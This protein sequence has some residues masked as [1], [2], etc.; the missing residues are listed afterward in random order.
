MRKFLLLLF[1]LVLASIDIFAQRYNVY[2]KYND[3]T[4][5]RD[6]SVYAFNSKR[7]AEEAC[8]NYATLYYVD[9]E[10]VKPIGSSTTNA[11]GYCMLEADRRAWIVVDEYLGLK[12][13]AVIE[14]AK[15]LDESGDVRITL[16][17]TKGGK[18][19]E[20]WKV[21]DETDL[22]QLEKSQMQKP[23]PPAPPIPESYGRM[24]LIGGDFTIDGD[25]ARN[26]A[27][28]VAFPRVVFPDLDSVLYLKPVVV[29]GKSYAQSMERRMGFDLENDK[30]EHYHLDKSFFM[31]SHADDYFNYIQYVFVD[32]GIRYFSDAQVWYEDYNGIY[33]RYVQKLQDGKEAKTMRFLDW[34]AAKRSI[35][36][37]A[38]QYAKEG[39]IVKANDSQEFHLEFEVGKETLNLNDSA[40]VSERNELLRMFNGYL[41]NR[42]TE[43]L[44]VTVKGYSSP[45]GLYARNSVLS[46]GRTNTIA[47]LLKREFPRISGDIKAEYDENN[48]VVPWD[49]I[50]SI[51]AKSTD[52]AVLRYVA[53]VRDVVSKKSGFDAQQAEL[54]KDKGLWEYV[55]D[56][57]L[58]SV[59]RV[60]VDVELQVSKVLTLEEIVERYHEKTLFQPD[61]KV[62]DYQYY[63]LMRWLAANEKWDELYTISKMAYEDRSMI[64]TDRPKYILYGNTASKKAQ[65]NKDTVDFYMQSKPG[66]AYLQI[67]TTDETSGFSDKSE[68]GVK[69]EYR[70]NGR[71]INSKSVHKP[72]VYDFEIYINGVV[73]RYRQKVELSA[74][75]PL[76][77]VLEIKNEA[78]DYPYPLAAYYYA[79]CMLQRGEVNTRILSQFLDD[80]PVNRKLNK[81]IQFNDKAII[82]TQVLMYCQDDDFENANRLIVTYGLSAEDPDLKSL[83][84]FVR[85]LAGEYGHPEIQEFIMS[86]SPLNEAVILAALQRWQDALTKLKTLPQDDA[87]IQYLTA[88]CRYKSQPNSLIQLDAS[89]YNSAFI[90]TIGAPMIE[91]F[92]LDKENVKYIENDGYFNDA[93]RLLVLY[94]WKRMSDGLSIDEISAEYDA[95]VDKYQAN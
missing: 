85:C 28:F 43:I 17:R 62:L 44:N 66:Y 57:V 59:R 49:T 92:K 94:F 20:E 25:L 39:K 69:I 64:Q 19:K 15:C 80:G 37:D 68:N 50:A 63:E 36:I 76:L 40:T 56:S 65:I 67:E 30:L 46:R 5:A 4:V 42:E 52:P 29:D 82:A 10:S 75:E 3:G 91:A 7:L 81:T 58:P 79:T 88:I 89:P 45:E 93:Y 18:D 53:T 54:R 33:H 34:D 1:V 11:D 13:P 86:T 51:M 77:L 72:G 16:T 90:K 71:T 21:G 60:E 24:K 70:L 41:S 87:R 6:A 55:K 73:S 9:V 48:N 2:I 38:T 35:K 61:Q 14:L 22:Q 74:S 95:L 84:M 83:I 27:R 12:V 26:D 23:Q 8:A 78:V 32:K 47:N 31:Q